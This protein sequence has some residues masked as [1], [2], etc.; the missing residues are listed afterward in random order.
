MDTAE[1]LIW[2]QGIF[3]IMQTTCSD[4][5]QSMRMERTGEQ[6]VPEGNETEDIIIE[7]AWFWLGPLQS[8][9][10]CL[11]WNFC[12]APKVAQGHF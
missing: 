11:D 1:H 6:E 10:V 5:T 7:T 9:C 3:N 12:R 2:I 4:L 8:C